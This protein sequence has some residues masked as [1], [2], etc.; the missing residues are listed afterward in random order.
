[1]SRSSIL[2]T[3][4]ALMLFS[5]ACKKDT[6]N[7]PPAA[8][9]GPSQTVTYPVESVTLT[10]TG[11]DADG[12]IVTYLWEQVSG[13]SASVIVDPGAPT[14]VVQGLV[15]GTYIY[16]LT[17]WDDLGGIGTDT[18]VVTVNPSAV[19][20]LTLQPSNNPNEF[21]VVEIGGV[22]KSG[23]TVNS[24]DADA[25]TYN[26]ASY[27][28]RAL[29]KF[30]LSAI[31]SSAT[32]QSAHLYLYSDPAPKSGDQVHA[33]YGNNAFTIQQVAT[34]WSPAT[35]GWY[36]QPTALTNNQILVPSTTEP[37]LDLDV[38]VTAQVASM[39]NQNINY[40]FFI[41]LQTE[42]IYA[43]RMFVGSHNP[44]Y[45]EKHPKLVVQYK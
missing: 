2:S 6:V 10:G 18:T 28:L 23:V 25:W 17:V 11:R 1:M 15:Q 16:Q 36:N 14:T 24:I 29:L 12:K 41:K 34:D 40:G 45:P 35:A 21:S 39:I 22:D 37:F 38:D 26:G 30:D 5:T 44:T 33:N 13:P 27:T 8:D 7:K 4:F 42:V 19:K 43:S 31:S 20:T 3:L 9:A 32:I